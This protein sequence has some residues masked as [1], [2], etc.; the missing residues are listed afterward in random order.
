[1]DTA[2][3]RS[4]ML[5]S[6]SSSV[7][8]HRGENVNHCDD[9]G[10][11]STQTRNEFESQRHARALN[12]LLH[13]E[14]NNQ[15]QVE[16]AQWNNDILK[17]KRPAIN[18]SPTPPAKREPIGSAASFKMEL[19]KWR[20]KRSCESREDPKRDVIATHLEEEFFVIDLA[21]MSGRTK[22]VC[23]QHSTTV[24]ELK[25]YIRQQEGFSV[26]CQKMMYKG[27]TI[28]DSHTLDEYCMKEDCKIY[29]LIVHGQS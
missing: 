24:L 5:G 3:N 22:R 27:L 14:E 9:R 26:E 18:V 2:F 10:S 20:Q 16:K 1:M 13:D 23:V 6:S 17:R 29:V 12:W 28:S 21:L 7:E 15:K 11:I 8:D 25:K 19:E 4:L